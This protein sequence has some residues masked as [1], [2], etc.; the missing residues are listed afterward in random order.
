MSAWDAYPENYREREI[1][2]LLSYVKAGD[3]AAVIGLSGSGKSNLLGFI[4]NRLAPSQSS[5][6]FVL[7]DCNR[8]VDASRAAFFRM[9]H[10]AIAPQA[11]TN[12]YY[13]SRMNCQALEE[14][15]MAL[16]VGNFGLCF[17]LDRFDALYSSG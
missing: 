2:L 9:L 10:R 14:S 7:V 4:A 6:K 16:M 12:N 11:S 15:L 1:K 13:Q 3:C 17:M 8:L 5:I